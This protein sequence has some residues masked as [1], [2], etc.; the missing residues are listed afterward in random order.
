MNKLF[1]ED[2][3]MC[4]GN[5]LKENF[6][7]VFYFAIEYLAVMNLSVYL[8]SF[9]LILPGFNDIRSFIVS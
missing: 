4:E 8:E 6:T 2:S 7:K 5:K 1:V 3:F 9:L